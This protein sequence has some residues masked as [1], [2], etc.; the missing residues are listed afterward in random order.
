MEIIFPEDVPEYYEVLSP[1]GPF[2]ILEI[3]SQEL[4]LTDM[5]EETNALTK[6]NLALRFRKR[7]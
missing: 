6:G 7:D 5:N 2:R 4:V 3:S 1:P